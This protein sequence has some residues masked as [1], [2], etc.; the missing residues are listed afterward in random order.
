MGV[1]CSKPATWILHRVR[2]AYVFFVFAIMLGISVLVLPKTFKVALSVFRYIGTILA[3]SVI[4]E[5]FFPTLFLNGLY[6][7]YGSAHRAGL[8][9]LYNANRYCSGLFCD[10]LF[11]ALVLCLALFAIWIDSGRFR[12]YHTIVM[13]V[14]IGMTGKR[15]PLLGICGAVIL[16]F[17]FWGKNK[18][19]KRV[20][21]ILMGI[22][23]FVLLTHGVFWGEIIKVPSGNAFNRWLYVIDLVKNN[24]SVSVLNRVTSGRFE[25][26]YSA[27]LS[28][29]AHPF[30]GLGWGG[31]SE[32]VYNGYLDTVLMDPHNFYL[33]I[34]AD[35]GLLG[36]VCF[37]IPIFSALRTGKE[38]IKK[39]EN[40][41]LI[42]FGILGLL[43]FLILG[44]GEYFLK[45]NYG[46]GLFFMTP[47]FIY[48][49]YRDEMENEMKSV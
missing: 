13:L 15:T 1:L 3:Y 25:A 46:C 33:E 8:I 42:K 40:N 45:T 5:Y 7:C 31:F 41:N 49:G 48:A 43:F 26:F 24:H 2:P 12:L 32:T 39:G 20:M 27:W 34:L 22:M 14:A 9:W 28:F 35:S 6:L 44:V 10:A 29:C 19:T 36:F 23:I 37:M 47:M 17:L 4:I 21:L 30:W 38:H 16:Y 18:K 11:T